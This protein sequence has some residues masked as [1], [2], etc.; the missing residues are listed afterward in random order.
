MLCD[1]LSHVTIEN[2][3]AFDILQRYDSEETFHFV[4]PPYIN[5]NCGHY[6]GMFNETHLKLLLEVLAKIKGKFMLT[7]YPNELIQ[8]AADSSGWTIHSVSRTI[9]VART[10]RR[11]QEEWMVC[12]YK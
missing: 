7:M 10:S 2:K 8:E 9:S 1:R 11:K 5:S 3:D 6:E 4:D 12:N